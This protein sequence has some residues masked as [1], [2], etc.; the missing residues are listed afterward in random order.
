MR[1]QR[2]NLVTIYYALYEGVTD[3]EET[4]EYGNP[5][6]TG[7]HK[8]SYSEPQS[9]KGN[10]SP[11]S[12]R[13]QT[14]MFGTTI[15]YSRVLIVDDM[16]CPIDEHTVLWVDKEPE[17]DDDGQ[18]IYEYVVKERAVSLHSISYALSKREVS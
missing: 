14:D 8:I 17:F 13:V 9:I 11:A 4:D 15:E 3:V 18:P 1:L 6:M 16:D 10:I 7:E 12:G 2:R 5:V